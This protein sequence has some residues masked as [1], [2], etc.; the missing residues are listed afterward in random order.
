MCFI[1]VR[2]NLILA[3]LLIFTR[4]I[5]YYTT[6]QA[7]FSFDF[8]SGFCDSFLAAVSFPISVASFQSGQL[9]LENFPDSYIKKHLSKILFLKIKLYL[10]RKKIV[11]VTITVLNKRNTKDAFSTLRETVPSLTSDMGKKTVSVLAH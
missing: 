6:I 2:I 1:S 10:V 11:F 3:R 4:K 5:F 9:L 7:F 8:I